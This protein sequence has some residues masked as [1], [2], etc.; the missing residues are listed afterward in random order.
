MRTKKV[1]KDCGQTLRKMVHAVMGQ[2]GPE[3]TGDY[4]WFHQN[5]VCKKQK[6]K[7]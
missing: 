7:Q 2:N 1:C 6:K 3:L 5:N 4:G